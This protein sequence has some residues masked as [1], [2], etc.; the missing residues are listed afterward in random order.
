LAFF[1]EGD[2]KVLSGRVKWFSLERGFGFA[3]R[4]DGGGDVFIG[5]SA[6]AAANIACVFEGDRL[7]FLIDQDRHGRERAAEIR[8]LTTRTGGAA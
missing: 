1:D 2:M 6:L 8:I 5:S 3:V 4:D 7:E